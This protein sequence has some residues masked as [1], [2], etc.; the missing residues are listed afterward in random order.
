M[1]KGLIQLH[2]IVYLYRHR[3]H[4][5]HISVMQLGHLLTRSCLT[6]PQVSLKVYHDSFCH[7]RSNVSLP[8]VIYFDAFYLHVVLCICTVLYI[9]N[10]LLLTNLPSMH[11]ITPNKPFVVSGRYRTQLSVASDFYGKFSKAEA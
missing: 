5:N 7:L 8:W 11:R 3:H 10:V 1:A 6:Y 2:Y 9:C 4:H